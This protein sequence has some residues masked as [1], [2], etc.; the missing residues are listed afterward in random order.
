MRKRIKIEEQEK[1][2]TGY[3]FIYEDFYMCEW[4]AI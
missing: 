1:F 3:L 2:I 4:C